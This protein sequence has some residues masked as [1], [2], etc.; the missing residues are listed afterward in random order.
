M[1][2]T[3]L[4]LT[5]SLFTYTHANANQATCK[6]LSRG[7]PSTSLTLEEAEHSWELTLRSKTGKTLLSDQILKSA[8]RYD[9]FC[10]QSSRTVQGY[11]L[12]TGYC[13]TIFDAELIAPNGE[14]I[15]FI[16]QG[17]FTRE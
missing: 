2:T 7:S 8:I 15:R 4:L 6:Q 11:S 17:N 1:K 10:N 12:F 16:C 3:I 5:M 13:K 14:K 9:Q